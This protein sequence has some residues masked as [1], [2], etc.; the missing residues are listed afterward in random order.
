MR[1]TRVTRD[2][3]FAPGWTASGVTL[4]NGVFVFNAMRVEAD[5]A[6]GAVASANYVFARQFPIVS[7]CSRACAPTARSPRPR[8]R[9]RTSRTACPRYHGGS[10]IPDGRAGAD[11]HLGGRAERRSVLVVR[12]PL[13]LDRRGGL[14]CGHDARTALLSASLPRRLRR[15]RRRLPRRELVGFLRSLR[16]PLRGQRDGPAGLERHGTPDRRSGLRRTP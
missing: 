8:R 12:R 9:R 10:A 1:L 7:P 4:L 3:T 13:G 2:G 6:G 15:Q 11:R 16:I 14:A 5:A